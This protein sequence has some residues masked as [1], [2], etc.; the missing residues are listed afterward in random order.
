MDA[1]R[2]RPL[3]EGFSRP[4]S[5][6]GEA[7]NDDEVEGHIMTDQT[8]DTRKLDEDT[9]GH[10]RATDDDDTEGHFR[11]TDD[12]DTEGHGTRAKSAT[13]DD[14][15][16]GHGTRAKSATDDDDTEGHRML[17]ATDDD[18]TEG[19]ALKKLS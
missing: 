8:D 18:D 6:G 16:E 4:G 10:F 11:A 13:D 15:T 1:Y 9:E 2:R 19:H 12:D 14:D 3:M 5:L 17:K 7:F